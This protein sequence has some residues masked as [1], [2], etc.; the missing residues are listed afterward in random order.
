[1]KLTMFIRLLIKISLKNYFTA[2]YGIRLPKPGIGLE[3][4]CVPGLFLCCLLAA[5]LAI[6]PCPAMAAGRCRHPLKIS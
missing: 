2:R 6:S 5:S 4:Q 1:M 3:L